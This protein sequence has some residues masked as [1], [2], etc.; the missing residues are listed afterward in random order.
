MLRVS[1]IKAIVQFQDPR[2]K[3]EYILFDPWEWNM[4]RSLTNVKTNE[5]K[6]RPIS[7]KVQFHKPTRMAQ[8]VKDILRFTF[9]VTVLE[10]VAPPN[11]ICLC[12]LLVWHISVTKGWILMKLGW[13]V[14]TLVQLIVLMYWLF[15]DLYCFFFAT[16]QNSAAKEKDSYVV[17]RLCN[18]GQWSYC[19]SLRDCSSFSKNFVLSVWVRFHFNVLEVHRCVWVR[20][21]VLYDDFI[22]TELMPLWHLFIFSSY[23][24]VEFLES[25]LIPSASTGSQVQLTTPRLPHL[26]F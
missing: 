1:G 18:K 22:E 6:I 26:L 17:P 21:N 11:F 23:F 19:H 5:M 12:V 25:N 24:S 15:H 4:V 2:S 14:G 7:L 16:G 10:T 3:C 9:F 20:S 8:Q 13:N